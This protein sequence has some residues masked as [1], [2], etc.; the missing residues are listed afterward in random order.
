[1]KR[2][3]LNPDSLFDSRQFGFSQVAISEPGKSVFISGQVAWDEKMNICGENDLKIQMEKS[4][5]NLELAIK[6]VGGE[7]ENILHLRIFKVNYQQEDGS[8][9]SAALLNRFGSENP[10]ASTWIDVAGLANEAFMIEIE[11]QAVV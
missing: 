5:D 7:L 11:A 6:S 1:M 3:T 2:I 9:I 4:L 10:P 8:I